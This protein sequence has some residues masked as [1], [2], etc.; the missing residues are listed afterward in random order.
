MTILTADLCDEFAA[1]VQVAD[2]ILRIYGGRRHF[3]GEVVT[4]RVFEDNPLVKS[5]LEEPGLGRVLV[6][7]GGASQRC[8]L[9]GG[10]STS[11]CSDLA[12]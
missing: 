1:D 12:Q 6:V 11:G 10:C 8:A 2:P 7:D 5:A 9:I 3:G 4:L